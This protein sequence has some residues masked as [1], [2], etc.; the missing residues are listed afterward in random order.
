MYSVYTL[1]GRI[2]ASKERT[3]VRDIAAGVF[4]KMII[5]SVM[6]ISSL[7]SKGIL[8]YFLAFFNIAKNIDEFNCAFKFTLSKMTKQVK[9]PKK[10]VTILFHVAVSDFC[11]HVVLGMLLPGNENVDFVKIYDLLTFQILILFCKWK[12]LEELLQCPAVVVY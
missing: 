6:M 7:S 11:P 3:L 10:S 8:A 12:E 4:Y 1:R 9:F 5:I 2:T